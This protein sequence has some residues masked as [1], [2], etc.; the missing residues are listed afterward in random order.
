M[1]APHLHPSKGEF[2]ESPG[3]S[4]KGE[5]NACGS[6]SISLAALQKW[7]EPV[8]LLPEAVPAL[9]GNICMEAHGYAGICPV[10]SGGEFA[11]SP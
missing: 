11:A 1:V 10:T 3:V 9:R 6:M 2:W 4:P 8:P 5:A 7:L